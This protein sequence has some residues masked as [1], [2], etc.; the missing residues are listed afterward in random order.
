MRFA[1]ATIDPYIGVFEAFLAAGW[2]PYKLFTVPIRNPMD[3]H[4]KVLALAEQQG[5]KVQLSRMTR[6]DLEELRDNGCEALVVASYNHKIPDWQPYLKYAVNFHP[7][8]L[9]EA[10]GPYPLVRAIME[11]RTTWGIT[12]HRLAPEMDA[13]EILAAENF[14]M[15]I[16]ETHESLRFKLQMAAGR[17]ATQV[18]GQF[19][20]LWDRAQPQTDGSYWPR[21]DHF[22]RVI[23]FATSVESI[24]CHIRAFG[25]VESLVLLSNQEVLTIKHAVGWAE[26]HSYTPGHIV[27]ADGKLLVIAARDGYIG[28]L[29]WQFAP[30]NVAAE[31]QAKLTTQN[32]HK[33]GTQR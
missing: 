24:K 11:R 18:A 27:R 17:L 28:I 19:T 33:T 16:D 31:I 30:P 1:I 22:D 4:D 29:E 7:S 5:A 23:N 25:F 3:S 21:W 13:G 8:P 10:R 2:K 15:Q 14:P 6:R 32:L 12:C 20:D 9:P 26:A